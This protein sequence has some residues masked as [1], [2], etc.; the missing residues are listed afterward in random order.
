[1]NRNIEK[2]DIFYAKKDFCF[3]YS[4]L[5]KLLFSPSLFY[6]EY[7][8]FDREVR[9]DTHLVEGKLVHCLLFE[10]EKV[11]EKF[12]IVPGKAPSDNIKKVMKDMSLYTEAESLEFCEIQALESLKTLNLFQSLKTDEQRIAKVINEDNEPYWKFL[13]NTNVDVVD[14]DTMNKCLDKVEIL[15]DNKDVMGLFKQ[16]ETDFELDSIETHAE[17]YLK[18]EVLENNF[19]LHGFVDFYKIDHD[20]MKVTICDLKTTGKTISDFRETVDF[21]NYWLQAAIYCKLV[22]DTLGEKADDYT[23]EFKFVVIDKYQQVYVF[24]VTE[25]TLAGWADGLSGVIKVAAYH[26]DNKN[27]QLPHAFLVNRVTL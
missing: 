27:F 14:H 20:K 5:N 19:G 15:K 17:K 3:S 10:P 11:T 16:Q 2:E 23:I 24:D 8:M 13:S 21:Y 4:S 12:N 18:S 25:T 26:Y 1:M 6:K 22:Y 7:I 9:T